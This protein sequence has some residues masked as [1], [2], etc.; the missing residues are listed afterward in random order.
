[1]I[2]LKELLAE[3][4]EYDSRVG[5]RW[6][7]DPRNSA[8]ES[9]FAVNGNNPVY[10]TDPMGDFKTKFGAFLYKIRHG[11]KI[12]KESKTGQYYV[13]KNVKNEDNG[14]TI[15]Y[16]RRFGWGGQNNPI[17]YGS[18]NPMT[19]YDVGVDWLTGRGQRRT[20]V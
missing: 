16:E 17:D 8:S 9:R 12:R 20:K 18:N 1:M 15:T 19:P 5:R 4:W 6:N 3:F 2:F 14:I 11:G 13:G 10:N 7:L